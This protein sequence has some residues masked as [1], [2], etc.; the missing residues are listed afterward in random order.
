MRD[1]VVIGGGAAGIAAARRLRNAGRNVLLIEA[2]DRLGGRAHTEIV[3]GMPLDLGCGWLHSAERNPMVDL[4]EAAGLTI[5]RE[6]AR[7]TSQWRNLGWPA[8]E[9]VE[10]GR[11]MENWREAALAAAEQPDDQPLSAIPAASTWRPLIDA[12]SGFANGAQLDQMSLKDWAA[13]ENAATDQN[14]RVREGYGTLIARLGEGLPAKLNTWVKR[15]DRSGT[16]L[17]IETD[18]GTIETRVAI[19]CLPSDVVARDGERLLPG[20]P[21]KI[22]AATS[23]PLGLADKLFLRVVGKHLPT[24]AHLLGSPHSSR[25]MGYQ[26]S[27]MDMPLIEC[28]IGGDLA[29]ALERETDDVAIGF[30]IGEL[31][32]LLGSDWRPALRPI[33]RSRWRGDSHALGSYSHAEVGAHGARAVLAAPVE[34]HLFFAGEACSQT[35]FSTCHGAWETGLAAADQALAALA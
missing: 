19:L 1:A 21:G 5:V 22:E 28:F 9:H 10:F 3:R 26:L 6:G 24:D 32:H 13:Y 31:T 15:I 16:A 8:S 17:R 34:N 4:A 29:D 20:L 25:T 14:W 18:A 33:A 35:D 27:P 23:L 30:A 2:R 7:W 11:A 12:I